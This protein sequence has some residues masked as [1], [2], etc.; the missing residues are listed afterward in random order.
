[1]GNLD[2]EPRV[3]VT[4]LMSWAATWGSFPGLSVSLSAQWGDGGRVCARDGVRTESVHTWK[5]L[6]TAWHTVGKQ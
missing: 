2:S 1:M 3:S 5:A 4:A 6:R